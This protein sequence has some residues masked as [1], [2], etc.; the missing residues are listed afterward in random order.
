MKHD[1]LLADLAAHLRGNTDRMVWCDTQLGPVA[2]A[3][4]D[5]FTVAKSFAHFQADAYEIKVSRADLRSDTTSGKWQKYAAFAHRVWFAIPRGLVPHNEIPTQCGII[6]R[7]DT[8]WRAARKPVAQHLDTL[9]RDAWLKLLMEH[10]PPAAVAHRA[11]PRQTNEWA[12]ARALGN[13]LGR[14]AADLFDARRQAQRRYEEQT[15]RLAG[16]AEQLRREAEQQQ[17]AGRQTIE[18]QLG[19][20]NSA[21]QELADAL[22]LELTASPRELAAA[23]RRFA[24]TL[25]THR[26]EGL[27]RQLAQLLAVV[28]PLRVADELGAA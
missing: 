21:Q 25:D 9:P 10:A 15:E 16:M 2:S 11:E 19:A 5:V 20:L 7:S 4:P 1:E 28:K 6:V 12:V 27:Q 13:K 17:T 8:G 23:C 18:R 3:R 24:D 14:E 26:I 22:G